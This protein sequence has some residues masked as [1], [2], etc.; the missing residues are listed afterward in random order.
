MKDISYIDKIVKQHRTNLHKL[1]ELSHEEFNTAKYIRDYLDKLG[2][3]YETPLET[4]TV[5]IIKGNNPKKTIAFRADIDALP[6]ENGA[7]HLCGHDGHMSILLGFLEYI[8]DNKENLNDNIVFV[9]QPAE[10][11]TGGAEPLMKAGIFK[12]YNLD[13]VYGLHIHPDFPEGYIG[14]KAGY[15]MAQNGEIDVE[16]IGKS[17]HGAI[18][19]NTIDGIVIGANFVT[20]VQSIVSRNLNP[21]EGAVLTFGKMAAGSIRNIIAEN[22]KLE[23]TMRCFNPEIYDTM[24]K[25]LFEFAKGFEIAYNCKVNVKI[26]DGYIAVNNDEN[27]FNEF[28]EAVGKEK[29][30]KTEPLMISED[31]SYYQREVPGLFFMQGARNEE[32]GFVNG[33]HSLRFDFNEDIMLDAI[34]TYVK[35]LKFKGSIE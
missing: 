24:K 16:I 34:K 2:I 19:Q 29:I 3:R 6:T 7:Q 5:G 22:V 10:E 21:M 20:S 31:F 11:D 32:K 9:F 18:P 35:L 27:L 23:G 25:R 14:C 4:A 15:L 28:V 33:L 26:E 1:A 13:E 30:T 8:M 17:G 12:K